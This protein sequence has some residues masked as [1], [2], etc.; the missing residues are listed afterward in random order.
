M[1]AQGA[2]ASMVAITISLSVYNGSVTIELMFKMVAVT[3]SVCL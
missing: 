3:I 2:V 1:C